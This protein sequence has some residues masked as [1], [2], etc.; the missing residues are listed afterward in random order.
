MGI[1]AR[2][3]ATG[4]DDGV[5]VA[6]D[7]G[8]DRATLIGPGGDGLYSLQYVVSR[9]VNNST[10]ADRE[11]VQVRIDVAGYSDQREQEMVDLAR[12]MA[13]AARA[14]RREQVSEPLGSQDRRVIHQ[15]LMNEADLATYSLGDGATKRLVVGL[16]GAERITERDFPP[17]RHRGRRGE[18]NG[19]RRET[20]NRRRETRG[21]APSPEPRGHRGGQDRGEGLQSVGPSDGR[22]RDLLG[23]SSDQAT[24]PAKK[25]S[26]FRIV[27]MPPGMSGGDEPK[28][29]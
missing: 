5:R 12:G 25:K 1:S 7:A 18:G 28:S 8:D 11:R 3:E 27:H 13:E 10:H 14:S 15:T 9:I 6:V 26:A 2:V 19:N 20:E 17:E 22:V 29:E 4:D 16:A 24:T 23:S 21:R